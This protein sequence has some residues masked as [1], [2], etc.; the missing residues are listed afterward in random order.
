[1]RGLLTTTPFTSLKFD[2]FKRFHFIISL[3]LVLCSDLQVLHRVGPSSPPVYIVEGLKPYNV[4]NFTV[5]LCTKTGCITSL[6]STGRTLPAGKAH[7]LLLYTYTLI[8][9]CVLHMSHQ[10]VSSIEN[11]FKILKRYRCQYIVYIYIYFI[12]KTWYSTFFFDTHT[13][14]HSH[15][16]VHSQSLGT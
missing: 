15:K 6:P 13:H 2:L 10:A 14:T 1:M 9:E 5:T 7:T 8:Q 12:L 3:L 4:Y 11:T 16:H